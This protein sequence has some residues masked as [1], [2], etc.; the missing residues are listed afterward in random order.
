[1]RNKY[2]SI[3]GAL[4][5][6]V[7][8]LIGCGGDDYDKAVTPVRVQTA[9]PQNVKGALSYTATV[10]PYT[11]VEL[12]FKVE[13]YVQEIL[14][15]EGVEGRLRDVQEGD[16]VLKGTPLAAIDQTE[17]LSKV[18]EARAQLAEAQASLEKGTED[19]N[20]ASILYSTKSITAPD[21]ERDRKE[22][23]VAA[24]QVKGGKAQV[25]AAEQ[26][27]AYCTLRPPMNGMVLKRDIEVGS[28]VRPG[29][30]AFVIADLS[31]V[32][33]LFSVPDVILGDIK[34]GEE[35][36]VT[37]ESIKDTI[38]LGRVTEIAPSANQRTRVFNIEITV[39][40]PENLL[41]P[42]MI[43]S[44]ALDPAGGNE[45]A[46]L[47]P[48]NSVVRSENNKDG[49]AVYVTERR[50][51]KTIARKKDIGLGSVYGNMIAVAEGLERGE[52]VIV[53]GAQIVHDGQEVNVI[54]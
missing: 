52:E 17:Y 9:E 33:V 14:Q 4:S 1:M 28:Y 45:P 43:A 25:V 32:K 24:A 18:V 29:T 30:R 16:E 20:R 50:D 15:V 21:Y 47:L 51:G 7:T 44:L 23:Q 12:D 49:Y 53:M 37:T 6:A 5:I 40:N 26:N 11:Q 38:F 41:K 48:L 46:I 31:S 8:A 35:M 42:G 34:L 22:Y 27:L 13:G 2:I 3:A 36:A 39:P 54:P 19:F 10:N